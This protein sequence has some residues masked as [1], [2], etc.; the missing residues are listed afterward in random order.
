[1]INWNKLRDEI[2]QDCVD[3]GWWKPYPVKLDR[4]EE[5]MILAISEIIEGMEGYR[6]DLPDD[7]LPQYP[8]LHVE[9]AD[10]FI[11]L[12]DAAGAWNVYLKEMRGHINQ[13]K[14]LFDEKTVQQQLYRICQ[15][16]SKDGYECV[17]PAI[18]ALIAFSEMHQIDYEKL[19]A[20]KRAYNK[21][22]ADHKEE[23]RQKIGGKKF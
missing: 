17:L 5:A 15:I 9:I 23:N 12:L 21:K 1:M 7:H 19:I 6:K 16:L 8:M 4:Y 10:A 13:M 3:A 22:R 18:L 14:A 11:R 20:E 2:H